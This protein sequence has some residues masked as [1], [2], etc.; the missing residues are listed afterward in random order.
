MRKALIK[1][2]NRIESSW[3][4]VDFAQSPIQLVAGWYVT[5][6]ML[7]GALQHTPNIIVEGVDGKQRERHLVGFHAGRNRM[8][9]YLPTGRLHAYSES[10]EFIRLARVPTVEGRARI[11]L[12]C[13]RY[14]RDF[15]GL[16]VFLKMIAMQFKTP[17]ALSTDVLE[18]YAPPERTSLYEIERWQRRTLQRRLAAWW[19]RRIK[20]AVL[21]ED[22]TQ[23]EALS[24]LSP[25][26]D[27]VIS[28]TDTL[29]AVDFDYLVP[30][31]IHE[32]LRSPAILL[33][34]LAVKQ[35]H[36]T[37]EPLM[38]YSDHDYIFDEDKGDRVMEPVFKPQPSAPYLYCFN[39]IGP[40]VVY[41]RE[42]VEEHIS[43]SL[44]D[45]ETQY[46]IALSAFQQLKRVCHIPEL[47]F[48]SQRQSVMQTPAPSSLESLWTDIE[49]VRRQDANALRAS[50]SWLTQSS[51][52]LVIPTRDGMRVLKPCITS[53]LD[54][55]SHPNFHIFIVDNGSVEEQTLD[56]F[57]KLEQDPRITIVSYPGEFNYSAINNFGVEQGCADYIALVNNDIEVIH[58]DWLT[59]MLVWAKQPNTGAVG[60]KLL[61]GNGLV[62]HAGV[63]IGM[64]NAA[65]HIHR[66]EDG[67]APGYQNRC[68]ATQNMMAVTAACL[69]TP[70]ALFEELGG[71]DEQLFKVAYNDIDYCL[72]V[73]Q[74]GLDI[75][76]TPEACLFH[77]ES[78]SRGDDMSSEHIERYFH[79]LSN[80]QK[81]WKTKGF[82][83]KYYSKHLRIG[84]EGVY[85]QVT[86]RGQD[87]LHFC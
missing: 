12:I 11:I 26:P 48:F 38:L 9:I 71:L 3:Q 72:R 81:R 13:M 82:V 40:S 61:F 55:T 32:R 62:Q 27:A 41:A 80:L 7:P 5:E 1:F 42:L 50:D 69:L 43:D 31:G 54:K 56:Y 79:E 15:F 58:E 74:R 37:S 35:S 21:I 67:T 52:D 87:K 53:I 23:R 77:H 14:L 17:E 85:P 44:F 83:D 28:N 49:W 66:L 25:A 57:T 29:S 10:I 36:G 24:E 59:Q 33:I 6:F 39:Y 2:A 19:L 84:D 64:G 22:E 16:K 46:L 70:R 78:V 65:G 86:V 76:W 75:I 34:K 4:D 68:I 18:F 47:L 73:E 63:T 30:L 45:E 51:V 60:A 20:V 8:L